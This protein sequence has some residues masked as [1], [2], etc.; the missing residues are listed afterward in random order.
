MND[1]LTGALRETFERLADDG[2]P[3]QGLARSALAGARRRRHVRFGAAAGL[4]LC[5]A[6]VGGMAVVGDRGAQPAGGPG[7]S[8]V[9]AYSGIRDWAVEDGSR[10]YNYSLLLDAATGTYRRLPFPSVV[11]SPDGERVLIST[12]DN[13]GD[14]P[15]RL[16]IMD[17]ATN[18]VRWIE[19]GQVPRFPGAQGDGVWSPDGGRILFRFSP[20]A[21]PA[22][23]VAVDAETL[24][25]EF[26]AVPGVSTGD[27]G[28]GWTPDGTGFALT[29][30]SANE[31]GTNDVAAEVLFMGL[32]G[33]E[34]GTL[35]VPDDALWGTPA[36]SPDGRRL[37][38][39]GP[40]FRDSPLS[41]AIVGPNTGAV[42]AR[43]A[44]PD[45]GS[46]Q[47]WSDDDHLVFRASDARTEAE[48]VLIVDL[49]GAVTK[50]LTPPDGVAADRVYVGSAG[51]LPDSAADLTF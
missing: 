9:V 39:W 23:V 40:A 1:R 28:L 21:A 14:H 10:A 51:G 16:G 41:V 43:F 45:A 2:P 22:G 50:R 33:H 12:G 29:P 13:S 47:G 24:R 42:E 17:R 31:A 11:P 49:S 20:Q 48:Q 3:P 6:L 5:V 35:K 27:V 37:A 36:F 4:A 19:A 26:V 34:R 7:G 46:F 44:V 8:V 30:S 18:V 38:L 25:A 15:S 32:D